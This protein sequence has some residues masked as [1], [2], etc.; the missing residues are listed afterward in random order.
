MH[1][2]LH[3]DVVE[4][5]PVITFTIAAINVRLL[6]NHSFSLFVLI[7]QKLF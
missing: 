2:E 6:T 5:A 4:Q 7:R 3:F 1:L